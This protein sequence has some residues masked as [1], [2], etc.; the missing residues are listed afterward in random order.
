MTIST[1]LKIDKELEIITKLPKF[2]LKLKAA[3]LRKSLDEVG[4]IYNISVKEWEEKFF[5]K[6]ESNS[7]LLK[8]KNLGKEANEEFKK[9][10]E[11]EI[12][13][14][15]FIKFTEQEFEGLDFE[16]DISTILNNLLQE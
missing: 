16:G 14:S 15:D 1:L 4:E 2:S 11:T 6:G 7:L 12:D 8:D 9:L 13:T 5:N 10:Q 3:K